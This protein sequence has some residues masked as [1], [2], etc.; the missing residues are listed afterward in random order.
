MRTITYWLSLVLIFVIPC[1]DMV[2]VKG[3]GTVS[4][5]VGLL[6]AIC[7]LQTVLLSGRFRK[8]RPFHVAVVLFMLWST[9]SLLWTVDVERTLIRV[10]TYVQLFFMVYILWDLYRTPAAVRAGLQAYILGASVSIVSLIGSRLTGPETDYSRYTAGGFN[11]N[12][13]ALILALGIPIA[14]YLAVFP[15]GHKVRLPLRCLNFAYV[16]AAL[17]AIVL[18]AGRGSLIAAVPALLFVLCTL[19]RC[20]PL[21][22][23]A[24]VPL[25]LVGGLLTLPSFLPES[26]YQRLGTT[27]GSIAEGDFG[28][29]GVIWREGLALHWAHPV[30]G[31]GS[32][33]YKTAA[34]K[35]NKVAH[36]VYLSVLVEVGLIGF[37][38][39]FAI[40]TITLYQALCQP[41]PISIL[42][43]IT[44]MVWSIGAFVH[45]WMPRKQT[46]LVLSLVVISAGLFVRD[47]ESPSSTGQPL[48]E[49]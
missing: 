34:V 5:T 29:R 31:V 22:R 38:L 2:S 17:T 43:L 20:P 10:R 46:W 13:I 44:L 6:A 24:F 30:L 14:W 32:G 40:L 35:T 7:W 1:E 15:E 3:V 48:Q 41:K 25:A 42:W 23:G 18:T 8:P 9:L 45:P 12:D 19:R 36:N 27:Y 21:V 4:R 47:D 39:F 33:A 49:S 16:P 37:I 11:P 28:G 26:S